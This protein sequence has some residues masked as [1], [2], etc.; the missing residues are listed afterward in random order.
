[1]DSVPR[2]LSI[3]LLDA[4]GTQCMIVAVCALCCVVWCLVL[5]PFRLAALV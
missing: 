2:H 5:E 3:C 1:M 4:P